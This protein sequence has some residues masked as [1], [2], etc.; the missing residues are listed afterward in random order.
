ML[1]ENLSINVINA[2]GKVLLHQRL[3]ANSRQ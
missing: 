1:A 2:M 3:P